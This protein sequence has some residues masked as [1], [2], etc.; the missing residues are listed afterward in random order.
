MNIRNHKRLGDLLTEHG[1]ISPTQLHEALQS[2]KRS[3]KKLGEILIERKYI[4]YKQLMDLLEFQL[5]ITHVE[6][7]NKL[8]SKELINLIPEGLIRKHKVFPYQLAGNELQVAMADPLDIIAMED[9]ALA[10]GYSIVPVLTTEEDIDACIVKYLGLSQNVVTAIKGMDLV[11]TEAENIRY[12]LDNTDD[13]S[14]I[15]AAVNEIFTQAIKLGASDIHIEGCEKGTIVRYRVDGILHKVFDFS[16]NALTPLVSRIK[17]M[18]EMDISEKRIPQDGRLQIIII[19]EKVDL[20]VSSMPTMF[21]EKL[22]IRILD[23]H[24]ELVRFGNLGFSSSEIEKL[25]KLLLYPYGM[26]LVTG[27]TGSGKTTTLYAALHQVRTETKNIATIEDPI[28]YLLPGINQ[29]Q[30]NPRAGLTFAVGLRALLR[31]DPDIIMLGE[32][33]D[34]ETAAISVRAASTGHLVLS[35]LHTNDAAGALT[36]LIDMGVEPFLLTSAVV[37]VISQRLVRRICPRCWERYTPAPNS[38]ERMFIDT[39]LQKQDIQLIRGTGCSYCNHTGYKGRMVLAEIMQLTNRERKLI[40]NKSDTA[41]I[42][43]A[44]QANGMQSMQEDGIAKVLAGMTTIE[45]VMRATYSGD[46]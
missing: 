46:Y 8:L 45:E 11:T 5:G 40:L 26:I 2:Q 30:I 15:I 7:S 6:V 42:R 1:I 10:T 27:P 3:G 36:R 25:N 17:L 23:R 37:G 20:R 22:V 21:G 33:R 28:E 38:L 13:E 19:N 34:Q 18:A 32:I 44:A 31:Q 14:P 16:R 35:T 39:H 24:P 41:T 9:I 12:D 29:T 4:T 43:Q